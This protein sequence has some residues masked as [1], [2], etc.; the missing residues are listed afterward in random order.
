MTTLA[1]SKVRAYETPGVNQ[2]PMI[3]A[4]IIYEGAAVSDKVTT[5]AVTG[6]AQPLV[7]GQPF[8]GFAEEDCDNSAGAAGDKKVKLLTEGFIVLP[9]SAAAITDEGKPVY[10]S[11]DDTFTLTATG[12][13]PIGYVKRWIS[14]GIVLVKF[15]ARGPLMA[16]LAGSLTGT[17]DG[18]I[19]DTAASACAGASAP[20][21]A[22]VDTCVATLA[23]SVNL[24][25]K[26]LQTV[27]NA[28]IRHQGMTLA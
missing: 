26:E 24:Q 9:I 11:D 12:N 13:S 27:L 5:G 23:T 14:T 28:L 3:A 17:V 2:M 10:A 18:T 15:K 8:V 21:A 22:Q 6:Y 20:T 4:D 16:T 7:A 1:T 25:L 19:V